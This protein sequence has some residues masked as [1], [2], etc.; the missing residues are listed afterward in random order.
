M[1]KNYDNSD[2]ESSFIKNDKPHYNIHSPFQ[3]LISPVSKLQEGIK[4]I[5]EIS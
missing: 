5:F 4:T 2:D 3:S 1:E